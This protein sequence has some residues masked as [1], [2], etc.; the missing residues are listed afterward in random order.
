MGNLGLSFPGSLTCL[1]EISLS[2]TI[3]DKD[4]YQS[5]FT[6]SDL[7]LG[8]EHVLEHIA[9]ILCSYPPESIVESI[10]GVLEKVCEVRGGSK[11][12]QARKDF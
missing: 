11:F 1:W 10:S 4:M 5:V 6:R 7:Y 12:L 2:N 9:H 3:N 8:A